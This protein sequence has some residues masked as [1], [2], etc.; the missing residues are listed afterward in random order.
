MQKIRAELTKY[1]IV[2]IWNADE[3]VYY[4]RMQ[5][6]RG[7]QHARCMAERDKARISV[8]VTDNG[9]SSG[10]EREPLWIIGAAENPPCFENIN[11]D[12]LE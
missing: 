12:M 1:D 4:W 3:T 8:L 11:R 2:D 10:F 5:P 6:N 9:D 7:L